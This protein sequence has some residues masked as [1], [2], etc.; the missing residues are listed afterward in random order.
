MT[1]VLIL[2]EKPSQSLKLAEAF[3]YQTHKDHI[4]ILPCNTFENGAI[5]VNFLGHLLESYQPSDYKETFKEWNIEDLP[6]F[7]IDNKFRV[8]PIPSKLKQFNVVK[9]WIHNISISEIVTAADPAVEGSLL[10][11]EVLY[12]VGNK[13]PVKTL[14]T[15]SLTKDSIRKAFSNLRDHKALTPLY[16]QGL[17]RQ[18]SDWTIGINM[19][20]LLSLT[21]GKM[22]L[23]SEIGGNSVYSCGRVQKSLLSIIHRRELEIETFM[24]QPY[25]DV[26]CEFDV[27]GV[28]YKGTWFKGE[29][30]HLFEK[31]SAEK[32]AHFCE[33]GKAIIHTITREDSTVPPPQFYNLTSLQTAVNK[34]TGLSPSQV[35]AVAQTLYEQSL[36]SYPRSQPKHV[37][38]EEAGLFPKIL[39]NL[40][41]VSEYKELM[42][43]TPLDLS[44][45]KRYVDESKT[46]DH[47]GII[48]TE[49]R[50]D[51]SK[52]S[53][54]ERVVYDLIAKSMIAAHHPCAIYTNT[55]IITTVASV[56]SFKTTGK[57]LKEKGWKTVYE[58]EDKPSEIRGNEILKIDGLQEYQEVNIASIELLEGH[59][60]APKRFNQANLTSIMENAGAYLS[61]EEKEG[62]KN[63]ALA[64]GTVATRSGIVDQLKEKGYIR[65][66]KNLVYTEIKGKILMTALKNIPYL[67]SPVTTGKMDLFLSEIGRGIGDF[68]KNFYRFVKRSEDIKKK[69]LKKY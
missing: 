31:K 52:L 57:E 5:V 61:E 9:K 4:E 21:F 6:I 35:L 36:I 62:F 16:Y 54:N 65:I 37:T 23:T 41:E 25:W 26:E 28:H 2:T 51:L 10:I 32:L 14:W 1:K 33:K 29:E 46:D 42:P 13:K 12:Y 49:E 27:N 17:A 53:K 15:T 8:K 18:Q 47:Y 44:L 64:I 60:T 7:P 38:P 48:L 50:V 24:S 30:T 58:K 55:E 34:L 67:T 20:R 3:R 43:T 39:L 22:G 59:T 40:S 69:C 63:T 11:T 66:E 45:N 56:F 68:K 19:T